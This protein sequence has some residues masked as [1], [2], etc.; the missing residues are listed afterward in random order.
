MRHAFIQGSELLVLLTAHDGVHK[1]A[2]RIARHLRI[3][4]LRISDIDDGVSHLHG[5][6][7]ADSLPF[8]FGTDI[9]IDKMGR[10]FAE[11]LI[12]D[13]RDEITVLPVMFETAVTI[14]I[15]TRFLVD[16]HSLARSNLYGINLADKRLHF[17]AIGTNILNGTRTYVT[18]NQRKVFQTKEAIRQTLLHDVIPCLAAPATHLVAVKSDT[19]DS[20][21]HHDTIKVF[22]QQQIATATY[23][24]I[25]GR[26]LTQDGS[27]LLSLLGSL[28]L[29]ETGTTGINTKRIVSQQTIIS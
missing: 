25:R 28:I 3:R 26:H 2:A 23:Y 12:F 20:R 6:R 21:V 14:A 22:C 11:E 17:C 13:S 24:Y 10:E 18:R 5:R 19:L 1:E 16:D 27:D 7:L 8:K 29:K 4:Q 9:T 15:V